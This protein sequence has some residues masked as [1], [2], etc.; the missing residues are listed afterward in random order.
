MIREGQAYFQSAPWLVLAP[1]LLLIAT[2]TVLSL[3]SD[4]ATDKSFRLMKSRQRIRNHQD[5][6]MEL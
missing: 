4:R 2:V 1:G 5:R 6:K 3:A